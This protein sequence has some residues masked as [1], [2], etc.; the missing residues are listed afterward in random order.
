MFG[1]GRRLLGIFGILGMLMAAPAGAQENLDQGKSAAQ[2]F[3]SDCAICHKS[4]QGLSRAGGLLGLQNFL[5]EHYTASRESAAAIARYVAATDKGPAP[6]KRTRATATKRTPQGEEKA[7]AAD[8]AGEKAWDKAVEK[9]PEKKTE[10]KPETGKSGEA[11]SGEAKSGEAKATTSKPSASKPSASK[12]SGSKPSASKPSTPSEAK[13]SEPKASE[14]QGSKP[15]PAEAKT[16]AP[17]ASDAKSGDKPE[18][19]D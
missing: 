3:A 13:D 7:K 8:K 14:A 19:S 18:K 5:R 4:T 9:K 11:K 2:L 10:K 6:A 12:P 16:S 1:F 15:K 17:N